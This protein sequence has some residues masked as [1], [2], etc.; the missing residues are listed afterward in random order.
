MS[1]TIKS[2]TTGTAQAVQTSTVQAGTKITQTGKN[3]TK[4][5]IILTEPIKDITSSMKTAIMG[6]SKSKLFLILGIIAIV[7]FIIVLITIVCVVRAKKHSLY[8]VKAPVSGLG[9]DE[10]GSEMFPQGTNAHEWT[11]SLFIYVKDWR[12]RYGVHK[13]VF[14]KGNADKASPSLYL[15]PTTNDVVFSIY[16]DKERFQEFWV[17]DIDLRRW[18]HLGISMQTHKVD[19]YYQGR[20]VSS[21]VLTALPKLN[22]TNMTIGDDGGFSGLVAH[23]HYNPNYST[24]KQM[25]NLSQK[26]PSTN[27]DYFN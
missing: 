17:R 3:I 8:I 5:G 1:D 15:S 14:S 16:T 18:C 12:Y 2:V 23:I 7:V 9:S 26:I 13:Q 11:M 10:L 22:Q 27:E 19:I 25:W 6:K 21:N 24:P 20:L 4:A